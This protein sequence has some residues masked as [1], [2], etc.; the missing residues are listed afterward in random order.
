M[1]LA[2]GGSFYLQKQAPLPIVNNFHIL[3][4]IPVPYPVLEAQMKHHLPST[5]VR[6]FCLMEIRRGTESWLFCY[7]DM[8]TAISIW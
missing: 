3:L 4:Q 6:D 1:C 2:R 8:E 5:I 7:G